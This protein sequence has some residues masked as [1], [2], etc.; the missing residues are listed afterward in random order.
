MALVPLPIWRM[1][2]MNHSLRA[3][4]REWGLAWHS[5]QVALD[6]GGRLSWVR[7]G[8]ATRFTLTLP[9]VNG[10]LKEHA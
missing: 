10:T 2:C 6:H 4:R 7:A 9:Q 8:E 5:R 1:S 3:S